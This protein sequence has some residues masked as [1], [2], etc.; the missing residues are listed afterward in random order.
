M[1]NKKTVSF[2]V[3]CPYGYYF[4]Y[5][6]ETDYIKDTDIIY[7]KENFNKGILIKKRMPFSS[8]IN[9]ITAPY[10]SVARKI[11]IPKGYFAPSLE[12][13][14]NHILT[15]NDQIW[16][17][18]NFYNICKMGWGKS[19]QK[20]KESSV[21]QHFLISKKENIFDKYGKPEN[22]SQL[23]QRYGKQF[24]SELMWGGKEF[25]LLDDNKSRNLNS[26]GA[27]NWVYHEGKNIQEYSY[28]LGVPYGE[29]FKTKGSL[30]HEY[31]VW[32]YRSDIIP[33]AFKIVRF[34]PFYNLGEHLIYLENESKDAKETLYGSGNKMPYTLKDLFEYPEFFQ[35]L[36]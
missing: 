5:N 26:Y 29:N 23:K 27:G 11:E 13:I 3:E 19:G 34:L 30:E 14:N 36:Y 35:P 4:L 22:L 18:F 15:E 20:F 32:H 21:K 25:Y 31:Y 7:E 16:M 17:D 6:N 1:L 2:E 28:D 33:K 10:F 24:L 12:D 9:K 8:D